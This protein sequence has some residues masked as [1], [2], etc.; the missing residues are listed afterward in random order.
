[1]DFKIYYRSVVIRTASYWH[2]DRYANHLKSTDS[3]WANQNQFREKNL[4][5]FQQMCWENWVYVYRGLKEAPYLTAWTKFN[6][7]CI[8]KNQNLWLDPIKLLEEHFGTIP[9][10]TDVGKHFL[11]KTPKAPTI[12]TKIESMWKLYNEWKINI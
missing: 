8:K 9:Q 7:T 6:C 12:R 3:W 10:D 1:M 11:E 4:F 2:K 5:F